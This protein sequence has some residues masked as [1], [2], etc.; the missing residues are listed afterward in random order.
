M[1]YLLEKVAYLQ[2][3]AE[4]MK[5]D[6]TTNEGKLFLNILDVLDEMASSIEDLSEEVI[7]S[8]ARIDELED[9]SA[10]LLDELDACDCDCDED[11]CD[12]GCCDCDE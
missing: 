11:D 2:G 1:G 5:I 9:I 4:G 10:D 6:E 12:C 8:E 3:L 7:K